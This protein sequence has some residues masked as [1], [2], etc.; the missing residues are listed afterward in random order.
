M[1]KVGARLLAILA[2]GRPQIFEVVRRSNPLDCRSE[3]WRCSLLAGEKKA[4]AE[5]RSGRASRGW[6]PRPVFATKPRMGPLLLPEN[7]GS[8]VANARA[9]A[10]HN[11]LLARAGC[12]RWRRLAKVLGV[13]C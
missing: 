11:L 13:W 8:C 3:T 12:W 7:L 6:R 4:G 5:N 2:S 9:L 10:D 1:L